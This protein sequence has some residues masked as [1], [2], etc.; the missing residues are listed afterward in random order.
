[1]E[2]W[3]LYMARSYKNDFKKMAVEL[4]LKEA[5]STSKTAKD[6]NIPLKTFEKWITSYKKDNHCFD[7]N[8]I[9][10][11]QQIANLKSVIS[12]QDKTIDLLKKTLAFYAKTKQ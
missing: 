7:D 5:Q 12:K 11:D 4:V 2:R 1:M 10:K 6:L 8:Y 3:C 9:S